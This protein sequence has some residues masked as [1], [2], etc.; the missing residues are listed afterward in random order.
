MRA[1]RKHIVMRT[2]VL[3]AQMDKALMPA[4]IKNK[5]RTPKTLKILP[6]S[7]NVIGS[8]GV[9]NEEDNRTICPIE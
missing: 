4:I 3:A 2:V 6:F 1:I 9:P 5:I 7:I 8:A